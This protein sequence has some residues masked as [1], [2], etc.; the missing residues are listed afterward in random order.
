MRYWCVKSGGGSHVSAALCCVSGAVSLS[1]PSRHAA[2]ARWR[3]LYNLYPSRA[4]LIPAWGRNGEIMCGAAA[5]LIPTLSLVEMDGVWWS[6][7]ECLSCL[8]HCL[9]IWVYFIVAICLFKFNIYTG[10]SYSSWADL[11]CD[12]WHPTHKHHTFTINKQIR[13]TGFSLNTLCVQCEC[14]V[15][16]YCTLCGV[17]VLS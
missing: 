6:Q 17:W 8:H 11:S 4:Q 5:R 10:S 15:Q 14:Y 2:L 12:W 16:G 7:E 3:F 9:D 1:T 13:N